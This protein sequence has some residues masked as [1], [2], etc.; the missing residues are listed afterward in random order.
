MASAQRA[1]PR[2]SAPLLLLFGRIKDPTFAVSQQRPGPSVPIR[3]R[4]KNQKNPLAP[5]RARPGSSEGRRETGI[6]RPDCAAAAAASRTAGPWQTL[7]GTVRIYDGP[8]R[9][10]G[11]SV[12]TCAS[13]APA[14]LPLARRDPA[15]L[16]VR[17]QLAWRRFNEEEEAGGGC[18]RSHVSAGGPMF[19][20]MGEPVGGGAS[21]IPHGGF[22]S[23]PPFP[24]WYR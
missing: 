6:Q 8:T 20:P 22:R 9:E 15:F 10:T 13:G 11:R 5:A 4:K 16:N 1:P 2:A 24:V 7:R 17:L 23:L 12:S 21:V 14:G 18:R 3:G 19:S